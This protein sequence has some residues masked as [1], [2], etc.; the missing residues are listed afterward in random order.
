MKSQLISKKEL[1]SQQ[2]DEMYQLLSSY[3]KGVKR[4]IFEQDLAEKN[5]VILLKERNDRQLQGFS[6]LL[7]YTT[8]F[9]GEIFSVVYSGDTI[10]DPSAWS[11]SRLSRAWIEAIDLLSQE[12][13]LGKLYWLLICSGYRTYRF[14]PVFWQEFYPR[15]ERDTPK[16]VKNLI[17]F[18]ATKK[19]G[20]N[21]NKST[22]IVRF[23]H[24][25]QLQEGLQ[26][27]PLYRLNDPH[28]SFFNSKNPEH[29]QGDELVC[30]TEICP[31]NLTKVGQ[32]IWK[33]RRKNQ[34]LISS[35]KK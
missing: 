20:K 25:H 12:F 17:D 5:W 23:P 19:F 3:F 32:R 31:N 6:T 1:S 29:L 13:S 10:V 28:V 2:I 27:I 7:L 15:F 26:G 14:L 16:E 33:T 9:K 11:S 35:V 24:P 30:L 4:D 8:E 22:G 34:E 21:Y 18:L